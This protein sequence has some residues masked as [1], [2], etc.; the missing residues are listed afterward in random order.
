MQKNINA[1]LFNMISSFTGYFLK[2][3]YVL[4]GLNLIRS[5]P[6]FPIGVIGS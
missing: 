1:K 2:S 4:D 5:H 6:Y 3:L